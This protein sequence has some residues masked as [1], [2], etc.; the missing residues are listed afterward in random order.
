ME[1][2]DK[3]YEEKRHNSAACVFTDNDIID[4]KNCPKTIHLLKNIQHTVRRL[5]RDCKKIKADIRTV[6]WQQQQA[7]KQIEEISYIVK[8]KTPTISNPCVLK[9][10][11]PDS[12]VDEWIHGEVL[13]ENIKLLV[14]DVDLSHGFIMDEM[15]QIGILTDNENHELREENRSNK[16]RL[17]ATILARKNKGKFKE[18]LS[19]VA[20][21]EFYPH[22]GEKLNVAYEAK[23]K[24]KENHLK[25]IRC[26]IIENVN[27]QQIQDHLCEKHVIGLQEICSLIK[28]DKTKEHI[29]HDIFKKLSHPELGETY[30]TIF[31]ESLQ[32]NYPH[33]AKRIAS[34][35]HLNC[36][37]RSA[38]LSY[39]SGSEGNVSE[40]STTT[41]IIPE[42]NIHDKIQRLQQTSGI[43]EQSEFSTKTKTIL[44]S[45]TY[46]LHDRYESTCSIRNVTS[47]SKIPKSNREWQHEHHSNGSDGDMSDIST[48][49]VIPKPKPETYEW[50]ERH[51]N[52]SEDSLVIQNEDSVPTCYLH[53]VNKGET[54]EP[55]TCIKS[56]NGIIDFEKNQPGFEIRNNHQP[57][58][59]G[60]DN[61]YNGSRKIRSGPIDRKRKSTDEISSASLAEKRANLSFNQTE[62]Y[63]NSSA[64]QR[65]GCLEIKNHDRQIKIHSKMSTLI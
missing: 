53:P 49:T 48:S 9:P 31:K 62:C 4:Q 13:Q 34:Q 37:C 5:E 60:Q 56:Q 57:H 61:P 47:E 24:E 19:L 26:F 20:K 12:G 3:D 32:E 59:E 55:Y 45:N 63:S 14:Q 43:E 41:T 40:L 28:K 39:P 46:E 18:F 29:W 11:L 35:N 54:F 7:K 38:D 22:I 52:V 30:A 1:N 6:K 65:M 25:C 8:N 50:I 42:V 10:T 17:L 23:K 21:E 36:V 51:H 33:I 16:I 58:L 15:L 27:I 44:Q 2:M 64:E